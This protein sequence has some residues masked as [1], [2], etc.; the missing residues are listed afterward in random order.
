MLAHEF[1]FRRD[2]GVGRIHIF[3]DAIANDPCQSTSLVSSSSHLL[4]EFTGPV[5]RRC[6]RK[7]TPRGKSG[8]GMRWARAVPARILVPNR[9]RESPRERMGAGRAKA[10]VDTGS[11]RPP[12]PCSRSDKGRLRG[13]TPVSQEQPTENLS[14]ASARASA[15]SPLGRTGQAPAKPTGT[16]RIGPSK[17]RSS[18]AFSHAVRR[19]RSGMAGSR[20]PTT[21]RI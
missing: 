8:A 17:V 14:A 20:V 6:C 5:A 9:N 2:H 21:K 16:R 19:S 11:L 10:E 15:R 13:K 4:T 18:W 7:G 12:L 1:P 3:E